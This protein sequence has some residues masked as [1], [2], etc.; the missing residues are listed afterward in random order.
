MHTRS[1]NNKYRPRQRDRNT[2]CFARLGPYVDT[3]ANLGKQG[4]RQAEEL[5]H[6]PFS[7]DWGASWL[8]HVVYSMYMLINFETEKRSVCNLFVAHSTDRRHSL[9]Q[10]KSQHVLQ[11]THSDKLTPRSLLDTDHPIFRTIRMRHR[12]L[13]LGRADLP[14]QPR[15]V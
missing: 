4:R 3:S 9:L 1:E 14:M 12:M 7:Q 15:I 5:F 10:E 6:A 11:H 2:G 13:R 8:T